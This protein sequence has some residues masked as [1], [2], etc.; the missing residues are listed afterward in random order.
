MEKAHNRKAPAVA[1]LARP[2]PPPQQQSRGH[3]GG[4][5]GRGKAAQSAAPAPRA[6]APAP[7]ATASASG[8]SSHAAGKQRVGIAAVAQLQGQPQGQELVSSAIVPVST[9]L[10]PVAPSAPPP[11]AASFQIGQKVR[12]RWWHHPG[13]NEPPAEQFWFPGTITA[14]GNGCVRIRYDDEQVEDVPFDHVQPIADPQAGASEEDVALIDLVRKKNMERNASIFRELGLESL[15][16]QPASPRKRKPAAPAVPAVFRPPRPSRLP[17]NTAAAQ[18]VLEPYAIGFDYGFCEAL[19]AHQ[20][21]LLLDLLAECYGEETASILIKEFCIPHNGSGSSSEGSSAGRPMEYDQS[22]PLNLCIFVRVGIHVKAATIIRIHSSTDP[23]PCQL[24]EV[25]LMAVAPDASG[26][27]FADVLSSYVQHL[28]SLC[29]AVQAVVE[30]RP[31]AQDETAAVFEPPSDVTMESPPSHQRASGLR[32]YATDNQPDANYWRELHIA[33]AIAVRSLVAADTATA[34]QQAKDAADQLVAD[35]QALPSDAHVTPARRDDEATP[36]RYIALWGEEDAQFFVV[37]FDGLRESIAGNSLAVPSAAAGRHTHSSTETRVDVTPIA[38]AEGEWILQDEKQPILYA[39]Q[40]YRC[41]N[42]VE[43]SDREATIRCGMAIDIFGQALQVCRP[44]IPIRVQLGDAAFQQQLAEL[45]GAITLIEETGCPRPEIVT[46]WHGHTTW[47]TS[48]SLLLE[49][50]KLH[51]DLYRDHPPS[52]PTSQPKI[53]GEPLGWRCTTW[54]QVKARL[55][56]LDVIN[57]HRELDPPAADE[58][59]SSTGQPPRAGLSKEATT[60]CTRPRTLELYCGRAGWSAAFMRVGCESYFVDWDRDAVTPSFNTKPEYD[61]KTGLIVHKNGLS[62]SHFVH[63]DF[64]DLAVGVLLGELE[65]GDLHAIHDGLDCSTFTDLAK[66]KSQRH[67]S[68]AF[69][70]TSI[71]AYATNLRQQFLVAFHLAL[72][73]DGATGLCMRSAENPKASRQFHPLTLNV[74]E[75][76]KAEG[77]LGMGKAVFTLCHLAADPSRAYQK[78]TCWWTDYCPTLELFVSPSGDCKKLCSK[79]RPCNHYGSHVKLR[80]E[81]GDKSDDRRGSVY[82]DGQRPTTLANGHRLRRHLC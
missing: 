81:K 31:E 19:L 68:N 42:M 4:G 6:V 80:P 9:A 44:W 76:S 20:T 47:G 65:L 24:A 62:A 16:P 38:F 39:H 22:T 26:L 43:A 73:R 45:M 3:G 27:G 55:G 59:S 17:P 53:A 77:G 7:A 70:G 13:T 78:E 71:A 64:L 25:L 36:G 23:N 10:V 12:G 66:S 56:D 5:R 2:R 18:A 58:P 49:R 37:R 35:A 50:C 29:D 54:A 52:N 14:L 60:P 28:A 11:P 30:W 79:T 8:L 15:V 63:L 61:E 40:L 21:Y 1:T 33:V 32:L 57:K 48:T 69:C 72:R 67:V 41:K 75:R 34:S 82:L 46:H 51:A 74:L